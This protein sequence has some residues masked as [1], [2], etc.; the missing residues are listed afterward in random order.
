M[1]GK[2]PSFGALFDQRKAVIGALHLPPFPG[3]GH[4][5]AR[6]VQ[7]I[8]RY[9]L[10]NTAVFAA[11]GV[12]ALFLQELGMPA[13]A[14]SG[15]EVIATLSVVGAAVRRAYPDLV[16]GIIV[17]SPGAAAPLAIAHATGA[18]FVRLK[19]YVGA[20]VKAGGIEEGCAREAI[21]Y[22]ARTGAEEVAIVADVYDRTGIPLG[23][24]S[25][26]EASGWAVQFGRADALV[27]TGKDFAGSLEMLARVRAR[28]Y[29]VPL[30]LGGSATEE[31]VAQAL[32]HA[33]GVIVSSSLMQTSGSTEERE[34]RPW[35][36]EK[37]R[38]FVEAARGASAG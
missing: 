15:P 7:E 38:R 29:G 30:L 13:G 37:I 2:S 36:G 12:D 14:V 21:E 33:D 24:T 20:M 22:R 26:E 32:E 11:G 16:L 8:E 28:G 25:I 18:Q 10:E 5:R 27:L 34:A 31:N 17:G 3:S 9:A 23:E 4:P 1:P 6:S 19:V 35:D